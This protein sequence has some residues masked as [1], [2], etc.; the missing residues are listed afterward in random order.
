MPG[1]LSQLSI[2]LLILAQAM[3]SLLETLSLPLHLPL[4]L[5]VLSFSF[6]KINKYNLQK[7]LRHIDYV[8]P[9][10]NNVQIL[11]Y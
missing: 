4:P 2:R 7:D 10:F 1:W 11:S 3:I 6:S 5:L 9:L 8:W